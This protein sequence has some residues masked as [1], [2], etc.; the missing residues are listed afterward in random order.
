MLDFWRRL[1]DKKAK[2]D[3]SLR[4][5]ENLGALLMEIAHRTTRCVALATS[6]K[7]QNRIIWGQRVEEAAEDGGL[8][9]LFG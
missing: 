7:L 8:A 1:R 3:L 6:A 5:V 9:N 4:L 2:C